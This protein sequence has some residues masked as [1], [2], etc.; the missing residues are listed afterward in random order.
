MKRLHTFND[1]INEQENVYELTD[2]QQRFLKSNV[3]G[4]WTLNKD[5]SVDVKGEVHITYHIQFPLPVRFNIIEGS[6][7]YQHCENLTSLDG[8]PRIVTEKFQIVECHNL[9][10]LEGAPEEIGGNFSAS[11]LKKLVSLKG[12]PKK[13]GSFYCYASPLTSL[14]GSPIEVEGNYELLLN[15]K[16]TTLKGAPKVVGGS[17][18][19]SNLYELKTLEYCPEK[20]GQN[21]V[22]RNCDI[23]SLN[24]APKEI[25]KDCMLEGLNE[26]TSLESTTEKVGGDYDCSYLSK[27]VSMEGSPTNVAGKVCVRSC[28]SLKT[29][30]G[31]PL[32]AR[33]YQI[34]KGVSISHE[35][36]T[37]LDEHPDLFADYL[38][39]LAK[40]RI[41]SEEFLHKKRG[42]I[43]GQEF[44]F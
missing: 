44:G 28:N 31:A 3:E 33:A 35:E 2:A 7:F 21:L 39:D 4:T 42:T 15:D 12:S 29:L 9:K 32:T 6:F 24:H 1:F 20:V 16:L 22:I 19:L 13:V 18:N 38:K 27:I 10:T 23:T 5:G 41:S 37:I 36:R 8:S 30:L 43:K 26:I 14:E 25:G 40:D 34:D 17:F 11:D